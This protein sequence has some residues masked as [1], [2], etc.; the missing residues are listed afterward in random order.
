MIECTVWW[1]APLPGEPRFLALLDPLE[2]ERH[3]AY[4]QDIDQ[5]RFLTG[6]VLAKTVL[7]QRLGLAPADVRFDATCD[8]CGKPHGKPR[9]PGTEFSISHSGDRIGLAVAGAPVGLDVESATRRADD[10]LISYALNETEQQTLAGLGAAE[11]TAA[12]FRYW[13]RKEALMKA[14]GKGLRIPLRSITLDGGR[15]AASGD[16]ALDPATTRLSDLDPGE[17]Y[18]AAVAVLTAEDLHVTEHHWTP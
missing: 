18:R 16:A 4:R 17:G 14:T 11:R 2:Q 3:R 6:R 5:R 1:A 9:L 10:S 13:T 8:D 12:F 15:L 7:G